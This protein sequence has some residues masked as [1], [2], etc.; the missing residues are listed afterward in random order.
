MRS[1]L[2]TATR[3]AICLLAATVLVAGGPVRAQDVS[4]SA[5]RAA[6]LYN[7]AK[8]AEWPVEHDAS[9]PLTLCVQDDGATEIALRDLASRGPIN[10]RRV[11]IARR[12]AGPALRSCHLLYVGDES[13]TRVAAVLD[14]AR[15]APVL[16]VGTGETFVLAGGMVGLFVED[17]RMRF[18]I[19]P[20]AAHRAGIR[21]SSRLLQLARI[22]READRD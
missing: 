7:F 21:L 5:L 9:R 22:H 2:L 13:P 17:G 16:T 12:A 3:Q 4:P 8:F 15:G 20:D 14:S 18:V 1:R 11:E 10:G 6:F 19:D